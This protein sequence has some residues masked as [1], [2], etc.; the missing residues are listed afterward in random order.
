[1]L[2]RQCHDRGRL[3]NWSLHACRGATVLF[4]LF[5]ENTL[6]ENLVCASCI[7][8]DN[9]FPGF[10]FEYVQLLTCSVLDLVWAILVKSGSEFDKVSTY[11]LKS[12][13]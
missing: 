7:I 9:F 13:S 2:P 8:S 12:T 10:L 3:P 4:P 5:L 11:G 1:M 6:T